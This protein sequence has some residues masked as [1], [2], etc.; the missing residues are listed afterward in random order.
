MN[1]IA[2]ALRRPV[3]VAVA[4]L[5]VIGLAAMAVLRMPIDVFPKMDAPVI[6]VA[7]PYGG[8]APMEMEG[9]IVNY[10][11]ANFL[12]I[13]GVQQV[14]SR[15]VQNIGL[16]KLTFHPGTDMSQAA[17]ETTS[18][19]ARAMAYMPKGTVPPFVMRYDA[20]SLP[21]GD[22]I[23]S[24]P[25][26]S[27]PE[28][29]DL[30]QTR[31]RPVFA[32]LPGVSAPPPFGGNPRSVIITL[33]PAR[34][35]AS[36][37]SPDDV[38]KAVVAGNEVLPSGNVRMGDFNRIVHANTVVPAYRDLL[39]LPLRSGAGG[40]VL[41]QDVATIDDAADVVSGYAEL[42]G[43]RVVYIPVTKHADASTLRVVQEVKDALPRMREQVPEDVS[44][45]FA[46]DQSRYVRDALDALLVDGLLGA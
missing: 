11:E 1:L 16:I 41:L 12:F 21:V 5:A 18:Y 13:S 10:Y 46:F 7:Q 17:A 39:Q 9:Y 2:A 34:L 40:T 26:R 19:I 8:M 28:L 42:N 22:L 30:A 20:G 15:S 29:D 43:R 4:V 37:L 25:R 23:L 35:S 31:I 44:V 24:S 45:D 14:E 27:Q 33:D 3:T 32:S 6:Y 38:V 36:R